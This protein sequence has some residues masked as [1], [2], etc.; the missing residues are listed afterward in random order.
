M[1]ALL[2]GI[3]IRGVSFGKIGFFLEVW[4]VRG[5][6]DGIH[7]GNFFARWMFDAHASGVDRLKGG[8]FTR[9]ATGHIS[10]SGRS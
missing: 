6:R 3:D 7:K 9:P 2:H 5:F 1:N 10:A 4:R 8:A